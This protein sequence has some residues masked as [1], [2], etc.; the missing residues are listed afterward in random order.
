MKKYL[1]LVFII[2]FA[3]CGMYSG[4]K[5]AGKDIAEDIKVENPL[6]EAGRKEAL[7]NARENVKKT[8]R[9]YDECLDNN[10]DESACTAEKEMYEQST[11]RYMQLQ[12]SK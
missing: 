3:G 8:R 1:C 2:L 10:N 6:T 4:T 7:G 5:K 9:N 11:E 12:K